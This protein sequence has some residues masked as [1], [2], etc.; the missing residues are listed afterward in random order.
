MEGYT[1]HIHRCELLLLNNKC[2]H[3]HIDDHQDKCDECEHLVI[4]NFIDKEC[5]IIK[6]IERAQLGNEDYE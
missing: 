5:T 1:P 6:G 3:N 4:I 2:P